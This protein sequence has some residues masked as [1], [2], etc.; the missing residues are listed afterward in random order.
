[1]HQPPML[2]PGAISTVW[3]SD[4]RYCAPM[5]IMAVGQL[6]LPDASQSWW[7][8]L[9]PRQTRP[10]TQSCGGFALGLQAA[11]AVM[12][13]APITSQNAS[14]A[15]S[16]TR[17]CHEQAW[18]AALEFICG[19]WFIEPNGSQVRRHRPYGLAWAKH[20][21]PLAQFAAPLATS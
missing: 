17:I 12:T 9:S 16:L 13:V 20:L 1:M 8:L 4:A 21:V 6:W 5:H 15:V 18:C 7:H 19:H 11:P 14:D 3:P 10:C 2:G